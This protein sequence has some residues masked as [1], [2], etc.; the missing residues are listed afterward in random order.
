MLELRN[1][2]AA[3]FDSVSLLKSVSMMP[4]ATTLALMRRGPSSLAR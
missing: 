1:S 4:G 2:R 3:G